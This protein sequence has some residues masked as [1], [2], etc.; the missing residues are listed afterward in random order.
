MIERNRFNLIVCYCHTSILSVFF[1]LISGGL[2][3]AINQFIEL[4]PMAETAALPDAE[5]LCQLRSALEHFSDKKTSLKTRC[6]DMSRV[7]TTTEHVWYVTMHIFVSGSANRATWKISLWQ[8]ASEIANAMNSFV[9]G[10]SLNSTAAAVTK[11]VNLK[12]QF[13]LWQCRS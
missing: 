3:W 5:F 7:F 1:G 9:P 11:F 2:L 6:V 8:L 12:N 13:I 4:I 10:R